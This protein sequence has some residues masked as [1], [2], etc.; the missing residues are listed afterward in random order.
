MGRLTAREGKKK[1]KKRGEE[2]AGQILPRNAKRLKKG[3]RKKER[4][5]LLRSW[6]KRKG[7]ER[8]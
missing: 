4:G 1:G 6:K 5:A 2:S 7:R 3:E 8:Q